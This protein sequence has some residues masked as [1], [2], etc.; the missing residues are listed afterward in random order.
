MT[1]K[2]LEDYL[3]ICAELNEVER[4]LHEPVSDTVS[5]SG[6]EFPF[7]QHTVSIQGVQPDLLAQR[8]SLR[9]QREEIENFIQSL[10]SSKLRRIV[11]YKIVDELTWEQ[12]AARMGHQKS[13]WSIKHDYYRIF[14]EK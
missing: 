9:A 13:V 6:S 4:R 10:P 14:E 7:T 8:D 1:K 3:H 5:G 2:M 12:I 11:K